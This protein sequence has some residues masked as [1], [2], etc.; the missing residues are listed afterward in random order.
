MIGCSSNKPID[1]QYKP[2][3]DQMINN[4]QLQLSNEPTNKPIVKDNVALI[5][6]VGYINNKKFDGGSADKYPLLIGSKTFI[7]TFEDQLINHKKGDKIDVKVKFPAD[8]GNKDYASKEA[9][10]KVTIIDVYKLQAKDNTLVSKLKENIQGDQLKDVST[11]NDLEVYIAEQLKA[12]T[13]A[14]QQA[15][16]EAQPAK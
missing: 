4:L 10:F 11:L 14:Q 9:T 6:Y 1:P 15:T 3:V 5:N 7:D 12:S 8:Y 2:Q 16:P 13:E